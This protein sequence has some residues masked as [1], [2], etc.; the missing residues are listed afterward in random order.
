MRT[1]LLQEKWIQACSWL[2]ENEAEIALNIAIETE[3]ERKTR[4][5]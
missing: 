4:S 1:P 2:K 3:N 5:T